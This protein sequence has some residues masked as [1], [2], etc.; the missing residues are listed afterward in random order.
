MLPSFLLQLKPQFHTVQHTI[1][2]THIH[3]VYATL[4]CMYL[5]AFT[6]QLHIATCPVASG[7]F[8]VATFCCSATEGA[9]RLLMQLTGIAQ[10]LLLHLVCFGNNVHKFQTCHIDITYR[11]PF[12]ICICSRSAEVQE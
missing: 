5:L 2:H 10:K 7:Q 8:V 6:W 4:L 11:V 9:A 12:D 3:R 1:T